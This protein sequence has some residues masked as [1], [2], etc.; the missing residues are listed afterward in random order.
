[1]SGRHTGGVRGT[2]QWR[3]YCPECGRDVAGGN[4]SRPPGQT[5]CLRPHNDLKRGVPCTGGGAFVSPDRDLMLAHRLRLEAAEDR[6]R[7]R[8]RQPAVTESESLTGCPLCDSDDYDTEL[9]DDGQP[10]YEHGLKKCQD[11]GE[12]WV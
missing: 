4:M 1:M 7:A 11:C 5:I 12:E 2:V 10:D 6:R 8:W 3:G 9:G